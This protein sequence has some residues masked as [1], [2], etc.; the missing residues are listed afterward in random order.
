M[1]STKHG[2][3]PLGDAGQR[4]QMSA[5]SVFSPGGDRQP[6]EIRH[7]DKRDGREW[8]VPVTEVPQS[9]AWYA[10]GAGSKAVVRVEMSGTDQRHEITRFGEDAQFLD[11]TTTS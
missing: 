4:V 7:V 8:T 3:A 1:R 6:G 10:D 11:T 5:D 2:A 9:V